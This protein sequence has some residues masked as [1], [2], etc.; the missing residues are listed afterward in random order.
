MATF[1]TTTCGRCGGCGRYSYNQ[2]DG[3]T[4]YGCRGTGKI[5]TKRGIK[6]R[7][8]WINQRKI[9]ASEIKAGMWI[10]GM[11]FTKVLVISVESYTQEYASNGSPMQKREWLRINTRTTGLCCPPETKFSKLLPKKENDELIELAIKTCY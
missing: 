8:W 11:G 4:C 9:Q 7:Q 1:E 10:A 3:D 5:Y 6:A 2:M